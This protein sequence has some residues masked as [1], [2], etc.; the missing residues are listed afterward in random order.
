[1]RLPKVL[2]ALALAPLA[3]AFSSALPVNQT[4]A[5]AAQPVVLRLI[6]HEVHYAEINVGGAKTD[7]YVGDLDVFANTVYSADNKHLV[8][9][10]QGVCTRTVVGQA[11]ECTFTIFLKGGQ[12]TIEGPYYDNADSDLAITGGTGTYVQTRGQLHMHARNVKG[13]EYDYVLTLYPA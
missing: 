2:V 4:S 6:E 7:S 9:S 5:A 10:D 12:L 8:G 11:S 13:T 3:L 1:M